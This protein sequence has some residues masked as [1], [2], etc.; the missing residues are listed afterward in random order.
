MLVIQDDGQG[1]DAQQMK[2][3]GLLGIQERVTR[4]GGEVERLLQ[5]QRRRN[6]PL[7]VELPFT[8]DHRSTGKPV[9]PLRILG[10]ADDHTVMRRGLRLLL[11]NQ[12]EFSVVADRR[13]MA[14]K[15]SSKQKRLSRMSRW[16]TS[17]CL[18]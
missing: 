5:L 17:P 9:K 15:R 7:P 8:E 11:E 16:L 12:P 6:D 18:I 14:G 10:L 1:F 13:Q 4:L 3:L 2:G